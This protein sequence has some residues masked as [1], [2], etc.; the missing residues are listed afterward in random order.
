MQVAMHSCDIGVYGLWVMW[1]NLVLNMLWNGKKV[2]VY[3]RTGRV[4]QDFFLEHS[5]DFLVPCYDLETF[6]ASLKVPRTVL[7][8]VSAWPAID[9]ILD[10]IGGILERGDRI[11][12]GGNS[13]YKDTQRR[14]FKMKERGIHFIGCGIS[15]G[16][17]GALRGPSMMVG[18]DREMYPHMYSL[19]SKVVAKDF[20]WNPCIGYFWSWG[21]WHAV[22]MVHNGIEYAVMEMIAEVYDIYRK[23]FGLSAWQ[24][25][26]VFA[27]FWKDISSFL[28]TITKEILSK[29][30][31][32]HFLIDRISD[33]A[34][35]KG[36]GK[37]TVIAW[38]EYGVRVS[39]IVE[40]VSVRNISQKQEVRNKLAQ[41]GRIPHAWNIQEDE[42]KWREKMQ[43]ALFLWMLGGYIEGLHLLE[44]M[45]REQG[46]NISLSEVLRV[47]QWGCILQASFLQ[48]LSDIFVNDPGEGEDRSV[49]L[50]LH[51]DFWK[52]LFEKYLG[53]LYDVVMLAWKY[54]VPTPSLSS[55]FQMYLLYTS[56]HLPTNLI[57]AQRDYFGAH[58]YYRIDRSGLFH[59][60][61]KE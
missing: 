39:S 34:E 14:F 21:A 42:E 6:I 46:W 53:D 33:V 27:S 47:W 5:S 26:E 55:M 58:G 31:W 22:K 15:W 13:Y 29:K 25:A 40:A 37:W 17:E 36:T 50:F 60:I 19:F 28:M 20:S 45:N 23:V 32:D 52:K 24:I 49:F 38:G 48:E 44:V 12:D 1:Q 9:D 2:A 56:K 7:L 61:W 35:W 54:R 16:Q 57:Q 4:T 30:E 43:H 10:A 8:M 41:M 51:S 59:S 18:G 11:I 3:N